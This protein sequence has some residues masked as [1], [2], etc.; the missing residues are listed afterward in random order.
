M[1]ADTG[2]NGVTKTSLQQQYLYTYN[3][4]APTPYAVR[5][6]QVMSTV[7]NLTGT[8]Q[9]GSCV[10]CHCEQIRNYNDAASGTEEGGEG[11]APLTD[12]LASLPAICSLNWATSL[13]QEPLSE[14]FKYN[15]SAALH[16]IRPNDNFDL[17][18]ALDTYGG[19]GYNIDII[20]PKNVDL[21]FE[22][23]SEFT[24]DKARAALYWKNA[25][26]CLSRGG[27]WTDQRTRAI[28]VSFLLYNPTYVSS[29]YA[30]R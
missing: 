15:S 12:E 25:L 5:I 4:F 23:F 17:E 1:Q 8:N 14:A 22:D 26:E 9:C 30:F 21:K 6:R 29:R 2:P 18:G 3:K 28:M 10:D 11:T 16:K 27:G 13:T 19:G 24:A 7:R 20:G